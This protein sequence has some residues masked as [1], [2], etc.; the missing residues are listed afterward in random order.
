MSLGILVSNAYRR[1]Q[2]NHEFFSLLGANMHPCWHPK[3][4]KSQNK[5][6]AKGC[7][8]NIQFSR[9]FLCASGALWGANLAPSWRPGRPKTAPKSAQERPRA[10]R[11]GTRDAPESLLNRTVHPRRGEHPRMTPRTPKMI[12]FFKDFRSQFSSILQRF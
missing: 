10:A 3:P 7:L 12:Q 5:G 4:M 9:S 8:K 2:L 11:D 6:G 1:F